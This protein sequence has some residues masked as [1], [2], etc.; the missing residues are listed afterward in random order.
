MATEVEEFAKNFPGHA[1]PPEL[2]KLLV[3]QNETG[4]ETYSDGFGLYVDDKSGLRSWSDKPEF[5]DGLLP[6]AQ[7]TG[8][9][10]FYALWLDGTGKSLS[11]TPVVACGDEGGMH[12]IANDVRALMQLLT[13]DVEPMI[14]HDAITFYRAKDYA[15]RPAHTKF[16]DWL[17]S[18]LGLDR[19]DQ[20]DRLVAAAQER[21]GAAFAAWKSAHG[22]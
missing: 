4:F 8:G 12:V 9:G 14:E 18:E 11:E 1:V 19:I 7:A 3:F 5:L 20:A 10:S 21:H 2:A 16:V 17:K 13:F 22:V 15:P 6:F